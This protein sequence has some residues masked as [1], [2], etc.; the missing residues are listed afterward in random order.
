[1]R[2]PFSL[3][4]SFES[5]FLSFSLYLS[6]TVDSVSRFVGFFFFFCC[7]AP[8]CNIHDGQNGALFSLSLFF[9]V[10]GLCV[11]MTFINVWL[12]YYLLNTSA[13]WRAK[14][15]LFTFGTVRPF[16]ST[17]S[18]VFIHHS[19]SLSLSLAFCFAS[20]IVSPIERRFRACFPYCIGVSFRLFFLFF[21]PPTKLSARCSCCSD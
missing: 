5:F 4:R 14:I 21:H 3:G 16:V 12:S 2:C 8:V 13:G 9:F 11:R 7:L 6:H 10:R 15:A 19:L 1:M 18:S 17:V 20:T